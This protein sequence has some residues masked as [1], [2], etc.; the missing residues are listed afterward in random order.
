MSTVMA[1]AIASPRE[2]RAVRHTRG[3]PLRLPH[4]HVDDNAQVVERRHDR[5]EHDASPRI[6]APAWTAARMMSAFAK[7]P[8]VGG[9]R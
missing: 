3:L 7:K 6:G 2:E 1:A 8:A 5:V 9:C 4:V